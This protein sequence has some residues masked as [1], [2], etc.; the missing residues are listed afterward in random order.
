MEYIRHRLDGYGAASS[1]D[2]EDIP[3]GSPI[4]VS[5]LVVARQH[6]ATAN[7]TVFILLEDEHGFINIIVPPPVY[8]AHREV[9]HHGPFLLI[10]GRFERE[11]RVMNVV[12]KRFRELKRDPIRHRSAGGRR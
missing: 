2:L 11:G 10:Q 5:G 1:A 7:G 3:D 9:I 12:A 6:P 4:L 8:A